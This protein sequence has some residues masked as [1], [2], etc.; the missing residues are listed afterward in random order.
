M[1]MITKMLVDIVGR[2]VMFAQPMRDHIV[3]ANQGHGVAIWIQS[4]NNFLEI[5][6][7]NSCGRT[8]ESRPKCQSER[9][10]T[11]GRLLCL[12]SYLIASSTYSYSSTQIA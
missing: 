7:K 2:D 11:A 4:V 12:K 6:A 1:M 3:V 5:F 10:R 8:C 9:L